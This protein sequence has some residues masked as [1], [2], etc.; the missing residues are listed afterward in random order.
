MVGW[1]YDSYKLILMVGLIFCIL[2]NI[3]NIIEVTTKNEIRWLMKNRFIGP[4]TYK[5]WKSKREQVRVW[6]YLPVLGFYDCYSRVLWGKFHLLVPT[7]VNYE[8]AVV[9][10][11]L[12]HPL[13]YPSQPSLIHHN[14]TIPFFS[15]C[16]KNSHFNMSVCGKYKA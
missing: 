4:C 14:Y 11:L 3:Q 7:C 12:L 10:W 9:R 2:L 5:R 6:F 8:V 16:Q 13:P 1:Y 15:T